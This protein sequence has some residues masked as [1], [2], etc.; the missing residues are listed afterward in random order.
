MEKPSS[1]F[2][3]V[4]IFGSDAF[5]S[6][7]LK[8]QFKNI[9]DLSLI[10]ND[11]PNFYFLLKEG[12]F[13]LS[14]RS[15]VPIMS[16]V[17]WTSLLCGMSPNFHG[18]TEWNSYPPEIEPH[19]NTFQAGKLKSIFTLVRESKK[20]AKTATFFRWPQ[21]ARI[22]KLS[23]IN[24]VVNFLA[25]GDEKKWGKTEK[26]IFLNEDDNFK[27]NERVVGEACNYIKK[28]KPFLTF[29]YVNEPDTTGHEIGHQTSFI[30][31]KTKMIDK[32]VGN[33][34]EIIR[35]TPDMREKTLFVFCAD[36]GGRG[37]GDD[38]HGNF[39]DNE[40]NVPLFFYGSGVRKGMFSEK[41]IQYD[42]PKTIAWL[43]GLK[44]PLWWN[45]KVIK[46]PFISLKEDQSFKSL[47]QRRLVIKQRKLN[48]FVVFDKKIWLWK[49][50]GLVNA[51]KRTKNYAKEH[52]IKVIFLKHLSGNWE[53]IKV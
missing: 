26:T 30:Y 36:H 5:G 28:E 52:N 9:D 8:N 46:S 51:L 29:I 12:A 47:S 23:E 18:F 33:V 37:R 21:F 48:L 40:I 1:N 6:Y 4:V 41:T 14:Q 35:S 43:L 13:T 45:G 19:P 38:C 10:K 22:L 20:T 11:L 2:K 53:T 49:T 17:N 44:T 42:L 3:H 31:Q 24:H 32:W 34:L 15:V 16:A 50:L 39:N 7:L 25:H 27:I